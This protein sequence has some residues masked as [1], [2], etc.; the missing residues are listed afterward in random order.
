MDLVEIQSL[1]LHQ[2]IVGLNITMM[3]QIGLENQVEVH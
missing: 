2:V 3:V 1:P